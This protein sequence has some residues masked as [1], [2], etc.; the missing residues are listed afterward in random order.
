MIRKTLIIFA[1]AF[2][3]ISPLAAMSGEEVNAENLTALLS[4]AGYESYID[5]DGDTAFKDQ[6]GMEY[7]IIAYPEENRIWIQSCWLASDDITSREAYGLVNESNRNLLFA[8]CWYEPMV[9][10]FYCDYDLMYPADG[11]D[12]DLLISMVNN[13]FLAADWYTDYLLG[14][15]AI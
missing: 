15:G 3:L 6:Y 7:W 1:T 11:L 13:F 8:R 2:L 9:R 12:D 4:D 10:T 14:E 5:E